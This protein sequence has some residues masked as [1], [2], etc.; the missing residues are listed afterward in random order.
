VALDPGWAVVAGGAVGVVGAL[1]GSLLDRGARRRERREDARRAD[2]LRTIDE[3]QA[4]Y[5]KWLDLAAEARS[6]T[7]SMGIARTPRGRR[8]A[9][10]RWIRFGS[11]FA[12]ATDQ[13][14]LFAPISVRDPAVAYWRWAL[15]VVGGQQPYSLPADNDADLPDVDHARDAMRRDLRVLDL[16][17]PAAATRRGRGGRGWSLPSP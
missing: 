4:L 9:A 14:E 17:T 2:H 6:L 5:I 3:R 13:L 15:R 12:N 10:N 11:K 16:E 8:R 1:G 7:I